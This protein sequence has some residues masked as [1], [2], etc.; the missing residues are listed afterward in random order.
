M[1]IKVMWRGL[2]LSLVSAYEPHVGLDD[3]TKR[4]FWEAFNSLPLRVNKD[5]LIVEGLLGPI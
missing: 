2:I 3:A 1:L 4:E 5:H